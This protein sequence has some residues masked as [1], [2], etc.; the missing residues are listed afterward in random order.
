M[1]ALGILVLVTAA[2]YP[3]V[4]VGLRAAGVARDVTQA[5]GVAQAR[6][7]QMRGM[8]YYVGREA[9][10][11]IDVLDTYYRNT[12]TPTTAPVCGSDMSS[13]PPVSWSGYVAAGGPRCPWEPS[14]PMYR[15][16]INPVA[17]PGLGVF[18]MVVSTQFLSSATP[19]VP[20]AP[21]SGYN[22]QTAGKD[23][24]AANQVGVTVAVFY[25][26]QN[27]VKYVSTYSQVERTTAMD[28]LIESK[29]KVTT[30]HVSSATRTWAAWNPGD[31]DPSETTNDQP[32]VMADMG[33]VDLTGELFTGSR[34]VANA[35]A[36]TGST[37]LPSS[38]SGAVT[39]LI[40]PADVAATGQTVGDTQ[41]P[42]GCRWICLGTTRTDQVS[43]SATD[44]LPNAG[45][46]SMPVRALIPAGANRGG[47]AFDNGIWRNKMRLTSDPMVSMDVS[48][49]ST[50][51]GVQ[52]CVVGGATTPSTN[53][54]L[55]ATGYLQATP[56]TDNDPVVGACA[57]AQSNVV[58][59]F[60]TT[61]AP[62]GILR[63]TLNKSI[64]NCQARSKSSNVATGDYQATVQYWNGGGYSTAGTIRPGNT[65]DPLASVNLNQVIHSSGLTLGDYVDSWSSLTAGGIIARSSGKS[66]E[67][68]V[69][70]VF[71]LVT[72]PT[73]TFMTGWANGNT[74]ASSA[75][76]ISMGAVS[77]KAGDYR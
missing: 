56:N 69:P 18:S 38:V 42:N 58:K 13:L 76:S 37:S 47:F 17:S 35:S 55:A 72:G 10:D 65:S 62:N 48:S 20:V 1:V 68:T 31:P 59:V 77:C 33:V 14:G 39:N 45:T 28:P 60:P 5:K 16:V 61:F 57:T 49:T 9:G 70:A 43:A 32:V 53:A 4:I 27:G 46:P 7:E 67:V 29:A 2:V 26:T 52:D 21:I 25:R 19:P 50:I 54:A 11:Y 64:A 36:A 40:A 66:A 51:P 6:L 34:V 41:L 63:V 74:D 30:V 75:I 12:T 23:A 15:R 71:T 8:P 73:R 22:S 3:Q 44:G 24:P